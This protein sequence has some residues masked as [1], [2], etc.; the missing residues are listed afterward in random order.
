MPLPEGT[1][2][3]KNEFPEYLEMSFRY[4]NGKGLNDESFESELD[5]ILDNR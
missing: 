2:I 1:I 5:F 4:F 3:V